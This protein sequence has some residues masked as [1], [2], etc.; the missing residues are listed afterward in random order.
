VNN[1]YIDLEEY[2]LIE[3]AADIEEVVVQ[4]PIENNHD[5]YSHFLSKVS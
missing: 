1:A 3:E 4:Q 5:D 2:E